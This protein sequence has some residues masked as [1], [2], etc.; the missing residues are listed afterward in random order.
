MDKFDLCVIGG[1]PSGYAA[2]IRAL[3][4]GKRVLLIE[5]N[6]VG[7]AGVLMGLCLQKHFGR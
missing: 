1:G 2:T 7:G 4:F 5:K 3:D 6:R